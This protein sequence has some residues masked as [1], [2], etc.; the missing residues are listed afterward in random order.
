MIQFLPISVPYFLTLYGMIYSNKTT[1]KYYKNKKN[2]KFIFIKLIKHTNCIF[3]QKNIV[4][5]YTY[6]RGLILLLT[7]KNGQ[8]SH[9]QF[10][11]LSLLR[12]TYFSHVYLASIFLLLKNVVNVQL[13]RSLLG[14]LQL[15]QRRNVTGCIILIQENTF[16]QL[17]LLFSFIAS[18]NFGNKLA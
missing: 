17:P 14:R 12:L 6:I 11:T 3:L 16:A 13:T 2:I 9:F 5:I 15:L 10:L 8:I 1:G 4:F 7:I 18:R